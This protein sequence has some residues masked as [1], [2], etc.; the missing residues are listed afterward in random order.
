MTEKKPDHIRQEDWDSVDSPLLSDEQ[1]AAMRIS[2]T[3][4]ERIH[5]R[6]RKDRPAVALS[7]NM[8][9]DVVE[10]LREV[11]PARGF[12]SDES[13]ILYYVGQSLRR[14]LERL[15]AGDKLRPEKDDD[16][17]TRQGIMATAE[18]ALG[19]EMEAWLN[20]PVMAL[21][22]KTPREASD[23]QRNLSIME[24]MLHEIEDDNPAWT[25][26]DFEAAT[27]LLELP[28]EIQRAAAKQ[29]VGAL[30]DQAGKQGVAEQQLELLEIPDR[31]GAEPGAGAPQPVGR[32]LSEH[33][34]AGTLDD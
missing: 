11:A 23:S 1:L 32:E 5:A 22:G 25:A 26:A 34:R 28:E 14:D 17:L 30:L 16:R 8:P 12:A 24:H 9:E 21:A 7:I 20:T 3:N 10:G 18:R 13:L 6:K 2:R 15:R 33:G 19:G 29:Q 31:P 4:P 27:S